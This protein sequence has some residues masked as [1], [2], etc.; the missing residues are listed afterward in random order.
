MYRTRYLSPVQHGEVVAAGLEA[1]GEAGVEAELPGVLGQGADVLVHDPLVLP[2]PGREHVRLG[3][4]ET[5]EADPD[6]GDVVMRHQHLLT[7]IM[8]MIMMTMI[9]LHQHLARAQP[10]LETRLLTPPQQRHLGGRLIATPPT[11]TP[12]ILTLF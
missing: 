6:V 2:Q 5:V 11:P 3:E 10:P 12:L 8:M 7:V 4:P 9:I 1:A